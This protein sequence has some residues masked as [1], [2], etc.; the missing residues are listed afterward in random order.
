MEGD[1]DAEEGLV[2]AVPEEVAADWNSIDPGKRKQLREH[3][4]AQAQAKQH[5]ANPAQVAAA[6]QQLAG[7]VGAFSGVGAPALA[8]GRANAGRWRRGW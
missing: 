3:W 7:L 2:D 6:V 5:K 1:E 8:G 4:E